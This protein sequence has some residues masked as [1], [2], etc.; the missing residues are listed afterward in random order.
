MRW[1]DLLASIASREYQFSDTQHPSYRGRPLDATAQ[2]LLVAFIEDACAVV[3]LGFLSEMPSSAG[4]RAVLEPLLDT[5]PERCAR[6]R[7]SARRLCILAFAFAG[8]LPLPVAV[9]SSPCRLV[10]LRH[11]QAPNRTLPSPHTQHARPFPPSSAT[12]SARFAPLRSA[13]RSPPPLRDRVLPSAIGTFFRPGIIHWPAKPCSVP[14]GQGRW[15]IPCS[16]LGCARMVLGCARMSPGQ[17]SVRRV[18]ADL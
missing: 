5:A 12:C 3:G 4:V 6:S 16:S 18:T 11:G 17:L 2:L 14:W 10:F 9:C 15:D 13:M 1:V 8:Q 7:T